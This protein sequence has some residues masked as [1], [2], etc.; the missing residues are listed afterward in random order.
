VAQRVH[1]MSAILIVDDDPKIREV[2]ARWLAAAGHE[3]REAS[4]AETAL[5]LLTAGQAEVVLCDVAM[6]GRGGLWL[7]A[8]AREECP[9]VAVVL[10][11]G[12]GNVHPSVSLGGNVVDYLIKPFE[13]ASV[14]AAVERG[15]AWHEAASTK[16]NRDG[17]EPLHTWLAGKRTP[18]TDGK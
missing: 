4:D 7:V 13:R 11:T 3:T 12:L 8:R 1:R 18:G 15:R 2:L 6:P 10:A 14:L 16:G 9:S 17:D 5:P